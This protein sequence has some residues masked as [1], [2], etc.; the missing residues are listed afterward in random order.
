M[1]AF[2][3]TSAFH[4]QIIYRLFLFHR[5]VVVRFRLFNLFLCF[6]DGGRS[7]AG[8]SVVRFPHRVLD[9]SIVCCEIYL[10]F[11]AL[12]DEWI[13][14]SRI[15]RLESGLHLSAAGL[16]DRGLERGS[17]MKIAITGGTGF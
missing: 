10:R 8:T 5:L 13:S 12:P 7:Y 15:S 6:R 4:P 2:G 1:D 14:Q 9:D 16:F 11:T 17:A 3:D